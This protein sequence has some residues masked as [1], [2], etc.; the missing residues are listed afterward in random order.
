M[1]NMDVNSNNHPPLGKRKR[2]KEIK[3]K[4]IIESGRKILFSKSYTKATMDEI[5]MDAKISKPTL[6]QYFKSKDDL[7]F[8]LMLPVV[9]EIGNRMKPVSKRAL[10][11]GYSSGA[12]L[13][14]DMFDCLY[15][16]YEKY[17]ESFR[18]FQLFHET[19]LVKELDNRIRMNLEEKGRYNFELSRKIAITA[20]D[21]KLIKKID[22]YEFADMIWG[23]FAGIVQLED[24]KSREKKSN[25]YLKRTLDLAINIII[26][27][28]S[29]EEKFVPIE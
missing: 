15:K 21:Q 7:F 6:Y 11:K 3:F 26:N 23:M 20:I 12:T 24:M 4:R 22:V 14:R 19:G 27:A 5:A 25:R 8:T 13:I 18:V 1:E 2:E 29:I 28:V 17:P 9:E 16:S 10:N